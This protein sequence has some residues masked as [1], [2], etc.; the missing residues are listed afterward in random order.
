[1]HEDNA[2]KLAF[3]GR[4]NEV[5]RDPPAFRAGVRNIMHARAISLLDTGFLNIKRQPL[6]ILEHAPQPSDVA[7]LCESSFAKQG[8]QE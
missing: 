5:G 1:V 7:D 3:T 2:C 4:N 6:V 8:S